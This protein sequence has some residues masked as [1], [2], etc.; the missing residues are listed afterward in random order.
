MRKLVLQR[1]ALGYI[2]SVKV[3]KTKSAAMSKAAMHTFIHSLRGKFKFNTG[4]KPFAEWMADM[5]REEKELEE[6]KFQRIAAMGKG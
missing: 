2:G 5:N 4:G 3:R 6:Q 1:R